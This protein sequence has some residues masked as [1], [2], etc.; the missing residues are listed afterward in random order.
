MAL[1]YAT[2]PRGACHNKGDYYL[3][4]FFSEGISE[5]RISMGDPLTSLRKGLKVMKL[6]SYRDAFDSLG[7]CIFSPVSPTQICNFISLLTGWDFSPDELMTIGHRSINLKRAI[8][9]KLGMTRDLDTM[10]DIAM[11]PLNEG[12]A[13]NQVPDLDR[14]LKDYY[15]HRKWDWD[16]GKPT[17]AILEKLGLYEIADDLWN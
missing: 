1:I 6:Q 14:L 2:G 9:L 11:Q 7:L 12:R 17:R 3:I 16:S 13:K 15:K 4:D 5:Y 8:N 10:P